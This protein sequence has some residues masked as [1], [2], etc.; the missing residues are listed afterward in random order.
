MKNYLE[1]FI[2]QGLV[3][4]SNQYDF[5]L[6]KDLIEFARTEQLD[7]KIRDLKNLLAEAGWNEK[8]ASVSTTE[9][10]QSK[11]I[12]YSDV[13]VLQT[14]DVPIIVGARKNLIE[15]EKEEAERLIVEIFNIYAA[16]EVLPEGV[17]LSEKEMVF[18]NKGLKELLKIVNA[19]GSIPKLSSIIRGKSNK[20]LVGEHFFGTSSR[21]VLFKNY[22]RLR[23]G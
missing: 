7:I 12:W 13:R 23:R 3:Y 22:Y 2:E 6:L 8:K 20:I 18:T 17:M 9:G 5:L 16:I 11:D 10:Y 1:M 21:T 19:N 4:R 15:A 14:R